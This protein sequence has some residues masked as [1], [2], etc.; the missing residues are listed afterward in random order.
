MINVSSAKYCAKCG[1]ELFQ[2]RD[3]QNGYT[4]LNNRFPGLYKESVNSKKY[5]EERPYI[6]VDRINTILET[7]C[8]K[9]YYDAVINQKNFFRDELYGAQIKNN[10]QI[11]YY[12]IINGLSLNNLISEYAAE[13]LYKI[14]GAR[15]DI[16][17]SGKEKEITV[18]FAKFAYSSGAKIVNYLCD[19]IEDVPSGRY[20]S[21]KKNYPSLYRCAQDASFQLNEEDPFGT[22]Q[23]LAKILRCLCCDLCAE[24]H[25]TPNGQKPEYGYSFAFLKEYDFINTN[26]QEVI[27]EIVSKRN[28]HHDFQNE[29][30]IDFA[31]NAYLIT[32]KVVLYLIDKIACAPTHYKEIKEKNNK[33][34]GRIMQAFTDEFLRF[35]DQSLQSVRL[36]VFFN[37]SRET[38]VKKPEMRFSS[39]SPKN[40][41]KNDYG[42]KFTV[43]FNDKNVLDDFFRT[44]YARIYSFSEYWHEVYPEINIDISF[45]EQNNAQTISF[46]VVQ[47]INH[48][49]I[50]ELLEEDHKKKL[51]AAE[52]ERVRS[53]EANKRYR[54]NLFISAV[55]R[56]LA[57]ICFW[58]LQFAIWRVVADYLG[59]GFYAYLF[60]SV[61]VIVIILL[62]FYIINDEEMNAIPVIG[63]VII[64]LIGCFG[65]NNYT[66]YCF[67]LMMDIWAL[68]EWIVIWVQSS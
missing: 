29:I 10:T 36:V 12:E 33:E 31:K 32:G 34:Y 53:I 25:Q 62:L 13:I 11:S 28:S 43:F 67:L 24:Y 48:S 14:N 19:A 51:I 27:K 18:E 40:K 44:D 39:N 30:S 52:Q 66:K 21:L 56:I 55:W 8:R 41:N 1:K 45:D 68:I 35:E 5:I 7:L 3:P 16:E 57:I 37:N 50:K 61:W 22:I 54:K 59:Q 15:N 60:N 64:F 65:G 20:E 42:E 9:Y 58:G 46:N 26:A 2:K 49:T 38:V 17:H 6:A 4:A 63:V 47:L 23:M